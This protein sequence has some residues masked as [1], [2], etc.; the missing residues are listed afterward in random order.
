[1]VSAQALPTIFATGCQN[2]HIP[3]DDFILHSTFL[4]DKERGG[5][6][7]PLPLPHRL[8]ARLMTPTAL[9]FSAGGTRSIG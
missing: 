6:G 2:N 3:A 5:D 7:V 8:L 9:K 1:M 4:N